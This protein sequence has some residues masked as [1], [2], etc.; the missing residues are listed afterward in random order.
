MHSQSVFNLPLTSQLINMQLVNLPVFK[1]IL[2]AIVVSIGNA[3]SLAKMNARQDTAHIFH[4]WRNETSQYE[5]AKKQVRRQPKNCTN[6]DEV[7]IPVLKTCVPKGKCVCVG[8]F[9]FSELI[10]NNLVS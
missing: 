4:Q 7:Y 2:L 5:Q 9:G 3:V 6:P 1:L 10:P 8:G